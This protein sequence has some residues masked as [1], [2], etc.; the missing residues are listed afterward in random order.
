MST[1]IPGPPL[2]PPHAMAQTFILINGGNRG[3]GLGLVSRFLALPN[4]VGSA[5]S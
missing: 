2:L 5:V 4:Y 1:Y 3:L